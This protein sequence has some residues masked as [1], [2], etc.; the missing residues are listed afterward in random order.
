[1]IAGG[2]IRHSDGGIVGAN[3]EEFIDKFKPDYA[4]ISCS[5][6][7]ETGE[8][9]DYDLREVRVTQAI[10]RQA[11]TVILAT[12]SM[13]FERSA[14]VKVGTLADLDFL[15]TDTGISSEFAA[16]CEQH[17]IVLKTAKTNRL[18]N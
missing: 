9:F 16:E 4:I 1:M 2:M 10:I 12:D 17:D 8:F 14:P 3:T 11:R 5:A 18:E 15:V 7:D 13:K 6:I